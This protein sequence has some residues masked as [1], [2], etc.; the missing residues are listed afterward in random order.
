MTSTHRVAVITGASR[1]I[2]A[3]IASRLAEEQ[4]DLVVSARHDFDPEQL[5]AWRAHGVAVLAQPA[6]IEDETAAANLIQVALGEFGKIDILVNNAGITRDQLALRL[7]PVQFADVVAVNLNGTYNVT[8]P[9]YRAMMKARRG[10]IINLA[11]VVG[12]VGNVG[13]AN[14]AAS[15]AGI[16]GLTKTLA[17]EGARRGVRVNAIAPGMIATAM[18]AS[19][20]EQAQAQLLARIPLQRF[21]MP[22]EV[23]EAA[24]F[25]I[26]NEYM[27]GQVL[28]IDGGLT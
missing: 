8:Q 14:Y 17:K 20:S 21:G 13:Q 9:A 24:A 10:V 19:L 25:L 23:A 15:K 5:A 22:E 4:V 6:A 11:S 12:L 28:T 3:A 26:H 7:T 1:G 27:T 16:I 2:G 18:T